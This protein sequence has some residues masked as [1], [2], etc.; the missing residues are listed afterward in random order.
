MPSRSP[1]IQTVRD[2]PFTGQFV[3]VYGNV[4]EHYLSMLILNSPSHSVSGMLYIAARGIRRGLLMDG[5]QGLI[6]LVRVGEETR[7]DKLWVPD[8]SQAQVSS[9]LKVLLFV[10]EC[11]DPHKSLAH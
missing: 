3:S 1:A 5:M 10:Y 6:E 8:N 11:L 9:C 4:R 7:D 2:E